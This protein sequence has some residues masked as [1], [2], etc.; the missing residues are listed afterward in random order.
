MRRA[1]IRM[2]DDFAIFILTHGRADNVVT[3]KTLL[4][5]EYSGRLYFIIDDEDEQ[6]D[7]YRKN[8]GADRV[9][10]FNKAEAVARTDTMDNFG[11]HSAIVYARNESFR[12]AKELGLT[13]FL[14]LDDD[15][16]RFQYRFE[17]DGELRGVWP[18]GPALEKIFDAM[19]EFLDSSGAA[20]VAFVQGGDFIGGLEGG[21][22]S[23]GL[24]RKAMN[25]F[26]CRTDCPIE[27][28]G[29]MNEDV[30]TY[31]TLG[32]RG[33]LFLSFTKFQVVQLQTQTLDGGMTQ[34]YKDGGTYMKS[35]Y[36]VMSMPSAVKV[37][38]L[39]TTNQ[40]IHHNVNWEHCVPKILSEEV[41]KEYE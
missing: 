37:K 23:K 31:T 2:R 11:N 35:M 6:A 39:N 10:V 33:V 16:I 15:Y 8:F 20:T 38:M 28:R 1:A 13:Y 18:K 22:F 25:T 7:L 19:I 14:M 36:A 4:R 5:Q 21:A 29:T 12:I 27:F 40:R 17:D 3:Y 9:I 41:R 30:V 26:F 32:S 24:L 34:S